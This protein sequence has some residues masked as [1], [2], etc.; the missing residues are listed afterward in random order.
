MQSVGLLVC[1][2]G[3]R[4]ADD[5]DLLWTMGF[6]A[7]SGPALVAELGT[8]CAPSCGGNGPP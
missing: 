5:L 2:E 4:S 7:A 8:F 1:A 6:G 3:V